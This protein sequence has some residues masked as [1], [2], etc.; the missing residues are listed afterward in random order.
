LLRERAAHDVGP[1]N[2]IHAVQGID[3]RLFLSRNFFRVPKPVIS[4]VQGGYA[5]ALGGIEAL[6]QMKKVK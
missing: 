2:G 6:S 3:R 5:A 4:A 1:R